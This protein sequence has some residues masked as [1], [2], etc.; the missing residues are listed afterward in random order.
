MISAF[1]FCRVSR[2]GQFFILV[3]QQLQLACQSPEEEELRQ[4]SRVFTGLLI[5]AGERRIRME[6][7]LSSI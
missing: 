1:L 3:T 4:V 5:A 6:S 7:N 2:E